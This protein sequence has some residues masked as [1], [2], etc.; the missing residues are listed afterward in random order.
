[1][2]STLDEEA[3]FL[4]KLRKHIV[5]IEGLARYIEP[6]DVIVRETLEAAVANMEFS[7]VLII[8]HDSITNE[9]PHA[10]GISGLLY[11]GVFITV[12]INDERATSGAEPSAIVGELDSR[13]P[14]VAIIDGILRDSFD[15]ETLSDFVYV[16]TL[17]AGTPTEIEQPTN[18]V[19][20][21]YPLTAIKEVAR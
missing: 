5:E 2:A 8:I 13:R 16:I 3:Q 6:E 9:E 19:G 11:F 7:G 21:S 10:D 1:M 20:R 12:L 14:S 4:K 15:L 18:A 17:G